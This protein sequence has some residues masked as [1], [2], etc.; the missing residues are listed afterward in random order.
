MGKRIVDLHNKVKY[1]D[2]GYNFLFVVCGVPIL[3]VLII[4]L[5]LSKKILIIIGLALLG[6]LYLSEGILLKKYN[7]ALDEAYLPNEKRSK[8]K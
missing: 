1:Y 2:F 3:I 6:M 7:K 5:L 8:K 4:G